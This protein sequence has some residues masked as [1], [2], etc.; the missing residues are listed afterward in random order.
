MI[1]T[2]PIVD[3]PTPRWVRHA[4]VCGLVLTAMLIVAGAGT[5][6]RVTDQRSGEPLG[7]FTIQDGSAAPVHGAGGVARLPFALSTRELTI[8]APGYRTAMLPAPPLSE[9]GVTLEPLT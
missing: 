1:A 5:N 4:A 7:D 3:S 9:R 2:P 8:T 6:V